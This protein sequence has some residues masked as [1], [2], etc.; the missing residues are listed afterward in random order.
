MMEQLPAR[1]ALPADHHSLA[2][3]VPTGAAAGTLHVLAL[4]GGITVGPQEGRTVLFGRNR[5]DVH[6][7]VGEND[8][9]VS[10]C[11]GTLMHLA[12]QWWVRTTGKLPLRLPRSRLLFNQD[13]PVPLPT[14]YT[15]LFVRGSSGREHL[16]EVHVQAVESPGASIRPG[17]ITQPPN[18]WPLSPV[19]RLVLVVLG[20]R[21]LLHEMYPNPLSWRQA[22]EHL[23]EIDPDQ[24]W[25]GKK[26]E[27]LVLAVRTRLSRGGVAG[28]TRDEV[29][30]PVGNTLN[31][32]LIRELMTST[33][34]VPP[35]LRMIGYDG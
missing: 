24:Q 15:P 9:R 12:D 27:H 1:S 4:A 11:Q 10:R 21:Y 6:V 32:N 17:D 35:D 28:L 30:E 22:A 33:T 23:H 2:L 13:D 34:L 5:P 16:I 3:G 29:G 19:E 7:C 31:H 26:V 20:Q 18:V 25:T 14:G 8:R